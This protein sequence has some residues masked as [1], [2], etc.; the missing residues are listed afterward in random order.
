MWKALDVKG[1][2][3]GKAKRISIRITPLDTGHHGI[4]EQIGPTCSNRK[5]GYTVLPPLSIFL[6]ARRE[7]ELGPDQVYPPPD[8]RF[9]R[10]FRPIP[11]NQMGGYDLLT[12]S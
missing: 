1:C 7:H 8:G 9:R 6:G 2:P 4:L 5:G 10:K 11:S 12:L 3:K